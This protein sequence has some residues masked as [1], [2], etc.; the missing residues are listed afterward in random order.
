[1]VSLV[2]RCAPSDAP[3]LIKLLQSLFEGEDGVCGRRVA[4]LSVLFE[5]FE[6]V[7]Q[8]KAETPRVTVARK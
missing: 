8:V 7:D 4:E 1:M 2:A 6:L 5:A 3:F